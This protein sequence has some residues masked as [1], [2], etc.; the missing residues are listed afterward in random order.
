LQSIIDETFT[1]DAIISME[2]I[3]IDA[4]ERMVS[5]SGSNPTSS[6]SSRS[7]SRH[8]GREGSDSTEK[9][10]PNPKLEESLK[11]PEAH[12]EVPR[13]E[14]KKMI[15]GALEEVAR[16]VADSRQDDAASPAL[17]E[18]SRESLLREG[19]RSWLASVEDWA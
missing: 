4:V 11:V 15:L 18:T 13:V 17:R 14:C 16:Q 7:G 9:G 8:R 2:D 1:E 12:L 6:S 10:A 3:L 19:I 5:F